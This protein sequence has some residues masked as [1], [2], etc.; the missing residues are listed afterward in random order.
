[1]LR[2]EQTIIKMDH[3][4][5]EIKS[6]KA[7]RIESYFIDA[8]KEIIKKEG[9][10]SVTVRKIADLSGYSYGSIYNYYKDLDELMFET[11]NAMIYDMMAMMGEGPHDSLSSVEDFKRINRIFL[12]FFIENSHIYTFFYNYPIKKTGMTP[13]EEMNLSERNK[14]NYMPFVENGMIQESDLEAVFKSILY[15]LYGLLT[16]YFSSYAMTK[17]QAHSDLDNIIEYILRKRSI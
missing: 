10:D 14:M 6:V 15:S 13:I 5:P 7:Q 4:N 11:R 12:D 8:A 17:E 3:H 1:M 16:L 9:P 2:N